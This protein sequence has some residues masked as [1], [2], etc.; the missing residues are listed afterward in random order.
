MCLQMKESY[1]NGRYF[2][3]YH[4]QRYVN[5]TPCGQCAECRQA[6]RTEWYIRNYYQL[7]DCVDHGG[8]GIFESLTYADEFLPMASRYWDVSKQDDFS[9]VSKDDVQDFLDRLHT[10]MRYCYFG[11][12][13][14]FSHFIVAEYGHDEVYKS[15]SGIWRK[16]TERPHYHFIPYVRRSKVKVEYEIRRYTKRALRFLSAC[17]Y[18][19]P[20]WLCKRQL[21]K[22]LQEHCPYGTYSAVM[23]ITPH[24]LARM[25]CEAWQKGNTDN[26]KRFA[27]SGVLLKNP[28]AGKN[29][30]Y[31]IIGRERKTDVDIRKVT[32][33]ISKYVSKDNS[34]YFP[35]LDARAFAVAR[36]KVLDNYLPDMDTETR[37]NVVRLC[38]DYY[39]ARKARVQW[40]CRDTRDKIARL[41]NELDFVKELEYNHRPFDVD[42]FLIAMGA[43]EGESRPVE[44]SEAYREVRSKIGLFHLQSDGFGAYAL[45]D[46]VFSNVDEIENESTVEMLDERSLV[47]HLPAPMYYVRKLLYRFEKYSDGTVRWFI[48]DGCLD[49]VVSSQNARTRRYV[50]KLRDVFANL[51]VE[52][53][54]YV[55]ETLDCRPLE[56]F[57]E[58]VKVYRGRLHHPD[59]HRKPTVREVIEYNDKFHHNARGVWLQFRGKA[60]VKPLCWSESTVF[61]DGEMPWYGFDAL[62]DF[63][64]DCR[65]VQQSRKRKQ[66]VF[67]F[68]EGWQE[69]T[70]M[71]FKK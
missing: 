15:D 71:H 3:R 43:Y 33:Y 55:D 65:H 62:F 59:F 2:D 51:S 35:K 27:K 49:K 50:K 17:G 41:C 16:G 21:H 18:V 25:V 6:K 53:R 7:K 46:G 4:M 52:E 34:E 24:D 67:D 8:F 11:A 20:Y 38:H 54:A 29:L 12:D 5:Q 56:D 44:L 14:G 13:F 37:S 39:V 31:N 48:K 63:L 68:K 23:E 47:V 58:Y 28:H 22:W 32:N 10:N 61:D 26:W 70:K 9:C 40:L 19:I 42:A 64:E 1:S 45:E 60:N 30:P 69:R 36:N 57:A 66:E